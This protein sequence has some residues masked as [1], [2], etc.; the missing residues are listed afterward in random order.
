MVEDSISIIIVNYNGKKWL[1][2]LFDSLSSQ[3]Y[4]DF[5]IVFVD[6]A[7][8]DNSVAFI[9]N[10]YEDS[11]IKIIQ[12]DK[13]LGFAGGN[14]L[15]VENAR[16]GYLLFMNT[17]VWTEPDFLQRLWAFYKTHDYDVVAPQ[18]VD[19]FSQGKYKP[20]ISTIDLW[21]D[22]IYLPV[23]KHAKRQNFFLSGFCFLVSSRLYKESLGLD[24]N[25]FMYCEE[26]DWFWRLGLMGKKYAYAYDILI[27]HAVSGSAGKGLKYTTFLWR[28]QNILQML[29]KNYRWRNLL[30]ILPIY[31]IQNIFE[32]IFF[33]LILKPKI[34]YSYIQG[35]WFNIVNFRE[36]I[37]KRKWVQTNRLISDSQIMAK[38]YIG[39]GKMK[40]LV[41]SIR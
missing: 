6:N 41:G 25:F 32:I 20:H 15:G 4:K 28:N 14:N 13:N 34:A 11:R 33:I 3:T 30:W 31:F 35:W 22:P 18:G 8:N 10:N 29:L 12:S 26:I 36:I 17:D 16:G 19:Y 5:E 40:H 2:K 7:S 39:F 38:M 1:K 37:Q 24:D 9:K 21:G 27:Y 23:D